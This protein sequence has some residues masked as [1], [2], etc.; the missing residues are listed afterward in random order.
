M[1]AFAS[2]IL[3]TMHV[4][5]SCSIQRIHS[6]VSFGAAVFLNPQSLGFEAPSGTQ[7]DAG[8]DGALGCMLG[9]AI[10]DAVG[11]PLEFVPVDPSLPND[12]YGGYT[13]QD[14]SKA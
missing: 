5:R 3:H 6:W 11:H 14:T 7:E 2:F 1:A 12:G 13:N 9:M 4:C 8:C 10:C